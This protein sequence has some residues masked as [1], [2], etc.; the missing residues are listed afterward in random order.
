MAASL[1][2]SV[3]RPVGIIGL[4]SMSAFVMALAVL[5]IVAACVCVEKN[6]P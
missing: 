6:D 2:E 3:A 5:I 4:R 1:P